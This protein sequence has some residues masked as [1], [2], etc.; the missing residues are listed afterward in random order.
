LK[1]QIV[2]FLALLIAFALGISVSSV[3]NLLS[4]HHS[5][6]IVVQSDEG[7]SR[8][9]TSSGQNTQLWIADKGIDLRFKEFWQA[10][11]LLAVFELAN[12]TTRPILYETY[13]FTDR[14]DRTKFCRLAAK[15]TDIVKEH[16][17]FNCLYAGS[18]ALQELG[19]GERVSLEVGK[20][21]VKETLNL[22]SDAPE[23][24]TKIGFEVFVGPTRQKQIVWSDVI[25]FPKTSN[26]YRVSGVWFQNSP[27]E[28]K[29]AASIRNEVVH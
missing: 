9:E 13:S 7:Q 25:V 1:N 27:F 29:L 2:R 3:I 22:S 23:I 4:S 26:G 14:A 19:A 11:D 10:K 20:W 6:S 5:T 17:V 18:I 8:V 15:Q 28:T 21:E 12:H 16:T 24:A